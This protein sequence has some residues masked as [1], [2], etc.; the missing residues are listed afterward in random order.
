MYAKIAV[1]APLRPL[2]TLL[3][4]AIPAELEGRVRPGHLVEVPFARRKTWGVVFDVVE[5]AGIDPSRIKPI[6]RLKLEDPVF[7]GERLELLRWLCRYYLY[8]IG[9]VCEAALPGPVRDGTERTLKLPEM[10]APSSRKT[11]PA[12]PLN[13]EQLV[14]TRTLRELKEGGHLLWGITGSGKTEV[15]LDAIADRL[16]RGQGALVLVPEISLTPLVTERFEKRFPGEV[17]IFHSGLKPTQLRKAWLETFLGYRRIA[18]GA[19]SALF[20]PI[21]DLG[22]IV[23]DEEHDGSYK[24]EDRLR[25]HARDGALELARRLRIPVV[26]GSAT[27]SAEAFSLVSRGKAGRSLLSKRAVETARLP[28][29]EVVDLKE[30]LAVP[31]LRPVLSQEPEFEVP[32]IQGD[33]FL[34]PKLRTALEETLA[35]GQQSI[36]FLNRRGL[37]SQEICRHCG[38][39]SS[40][41][42]CDVKLTPHERAQICHYCGYSQPTPET[43]PECKAEDKPFVRVGVGTEAIEEA[44]RFHFPKARVLR[45]DRDTAENPESLRK[46]LEVFGEGRADILIGTQMVAKGHDFPNVTLVGI[47]LADIGLGVPDFRASERALQLLLQVSGRAGRALHPGRV[48][49]QTFQPEHPVFEALRTMKGLEDYGRFLEEEIAKRE[50]LLYPPSGRL[51]VLRFDGIEEGLVQEASRSVAKALRRAESEDFRVLGPAPCPLSRIR[52]RYRW[53]I[54][55]KSK[56]EARLEKTL[57]WILDGW[58]ENKLERKYKTRIVVDADAYQML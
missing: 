46:I 24:Q 35:A 22:L 44:V 14:A 47:L 55:V 53:Q 19:R 28:E 33:F 29:I 48:L 6:T 45:L 26:L 4:Y 15:Y 27:P 5:R 41:P 13:D 16:K 10:P 42:S 11:V 36:L 31:N 32:T 1:P 25:Y 17:A 3:D 2:E 37:G 56:D 52:G 23:I 39:T 9:E 38:Y 12:P 43:C 8:P 34:S 18:V 54:L 20:A 51:T 50:G 40:C 57:G 7:T 49:L 30:Q 58:D 21:R